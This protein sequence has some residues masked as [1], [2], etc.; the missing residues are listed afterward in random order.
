MAADTRYVLLGY[1]RIG[2]CGACAEI[3]CDGEMR[4]SI[5]LK[6]VAACVCLT[7]QKLALAQK[8]LLPTSSQHGING[9]RI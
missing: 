4:H 1:T 9:W 3:Q 8:G 5:H 7:V 6:K 2:D